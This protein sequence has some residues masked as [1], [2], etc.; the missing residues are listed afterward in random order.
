MMGIESEKDFRYF[1]VPSPHSSC[2]PF[3][4]PSI[5]RMLSAQ[6]AMSHGFLQNT[7]HNPLY[8]ISPDNSVIS[9]SSFW[10]RFNG[11]KHAPIDVA[12]VPSL[13]SARFARR[14][15]FA[16]FPHRGACSQAAI[17]V[18]TSSKIRVRYVP[19]NPPPLLYSIKGLGW[20]KF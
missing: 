1:P 15:F 16:L 7:H 11:G 9:L 2:F 20:K 10:L 3:L 18:E 12:C 19:F 4:V 5:S 6:R 8:L 13:R 14:F 17:D